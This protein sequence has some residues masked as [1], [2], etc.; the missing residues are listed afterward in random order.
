[1]QS[2]RS[3][4]KNR[5]GVSPAVSTVIITAVS[6]VL[7]LV[8]GNYALQVLASQR[9]I[10][11]FETA[12][13][14]MLA[15]DD[16]VRDIAWDQSGSRSIRFTNSYGNM[17]LI[18]NSKT[19]TITGL[20]GIYH[21][22]FTTAAVKY[23]MPTGWGMPGIP[24]SY[25]VGDNSTVISSLTDSMG[26]AQMKHEAGFNSITLN[27]RVRV[28][29]EGSLEIDAITYHYVDIFVIRLNC[30]SST[31][32]AGDFNLVC[33]NVGLTTKRSD[34]YPVGTSPSLSV[35]DGGEPFEV[36][37]SYLKSGNVIF[38]LVISDVRV[39]Y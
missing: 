2:K 29:Y 25:I 16:A 17:R 10:A 24:A 20:N 4:R 8:A 21:D 33:K 22:T 32:G 6:V 38:T 23:Q 12:Q 7:V 1:M 15:F 34:P 3:L 37:L 30:N 9:A 28:S 18:A 13:N 27:Y 31:I 5:R 14:S 39:S 11:E 36:D 19:F 26:Q 35:S